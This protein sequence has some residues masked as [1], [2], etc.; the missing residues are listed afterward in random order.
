MN[1]R[2]SAGARRPLLLESDQ[3]PKQ[4]NEGASLQPEGE[5]F[6]HAPAIEV[7]RQLAMT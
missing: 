1:P 2:S 3:A 4:V 7:G 5:V 6:D